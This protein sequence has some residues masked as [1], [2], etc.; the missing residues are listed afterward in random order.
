[1]QYQFVDIEINRQLEPIREPAGAGRI[2]LLVRRAT[3][4]VGFSMCE[5]KQGAGLSVPEMEEMI[6]PELKVKIVSVAIADELTLAE[7]RPA[8]LHP[9]PLCARAPALPCWPDAWTRFVH[10]ATGAT[11]NF[12]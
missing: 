4:P 2:A 9:L 10:F 7:W 8:L 12:S 11:S 5:T 3:W 1:V 6:G